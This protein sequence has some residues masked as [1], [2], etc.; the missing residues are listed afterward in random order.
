MP[1]NVKIEYTDEVVVIEQGVRAEEKQG[2]LVVYDQDGIVTAK[3]SLSK[4]EH[5]W[6]ASK[7][8]EF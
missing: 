7:K 3:F 6:T 5:S 2:S 8:E 4:V 1:I